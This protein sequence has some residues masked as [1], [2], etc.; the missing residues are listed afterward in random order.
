MRLLWRVFCLTL[1][2]LSDTEPRVNG[3]RIVAVFLLGLLCSGCV[4]KEVR[5]KSKVGPEFRHKGSSRTE[6]ERWTV[7]EGLEFKWN[8]GV[9]T[10][11][12]YRRRDVN[13]GSGDHDDGVWFEFSFPVWKAKPLPLA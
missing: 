4:L 5:S 8:N 6:S 11:V 9:S 12:T 7:Q 3:P 2:R 13:E 10:G 1:S